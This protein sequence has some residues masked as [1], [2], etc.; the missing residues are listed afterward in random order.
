M[1]H[2]ILSDVKY[3]R[4]LGIIYLFSGL[5]LTFFGFLTLTIIIG[6]F[7][8]IGGFVLISFSFMNLSGYRDGKCPYCHNEIKVVASAKT[9]KCP[10]CKKISTVVENTLERID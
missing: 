1:E 8:I 3:N 2:S 6:I 9:F 4:V 10:R 7:G 5:L